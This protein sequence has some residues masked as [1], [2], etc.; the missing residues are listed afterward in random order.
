MLWTDLDD[1]ATPRI[2]V[3]VIK[4][5]TLQVARRKFISFFL[6]NCSSQTFCNNTLW[7]LSYFYYLLICSIYC[8][9]VYISRQNSF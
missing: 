5:Y 9:V 4:C 8:I 6:L 7:K 1:S 2:D 3:N